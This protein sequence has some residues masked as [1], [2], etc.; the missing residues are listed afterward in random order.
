MIQIK[1]LI[2]KYIR[3]DIDGNEAGSETVLDGINLQI[4]EGEFVAILGR[5]GSGKSTFAKQLNAILRPS[6]GR[7]LV[8]GLDSNDDDNKYKIRRKAGMVF[9]NPDNQMV[10]S[11]V[12]EDVAFGPENLGLEPDEIKDKV[13]N[14]LKSVRMWN[15][16]DV[17]TGRLSGGQKQRVAIAGVLAMKPDYIILDEPTAMLDPEG[18]KEVIDTV[19]RLNKEK[20]M[21]VVLITHNIEEAINADRVVVLENGRVCADDTPDRIFMDKELIYKNGIT[22]PFEYRVWREISGGRKATV[23]NIEQLADKIAEL[24][25][26]RADITGDRME[27]AGCRTELDGHRVQAVAE[28][29]SDDKCTGT[30]NIS[31]DDESML[32]L[33]DVSYVYNPNTAYEKTAVRDISVAFKRGEFVGI[34]GHTGS[35]KSTLIQLFNGLLSPTNGCVMY[36]GKDI[37]SKETSKKYV[38]SKIGMVFQYP[39]HQMVKDT[40]YEDVTFGPGNLNLDKAECE[41]RAKTSLSMVGIPEEMWDKSPLQL[42]GGQ[43][44][45]VAIAGVLAMKPDFIILD[46]PAAGL[47]AEGKCEIFDWLRK[48]CEDDN[49]GIILVSHSMED[50]A[51]YAD[52]MIVLNDGRLIYD[53]TP[54]TVFSHSEELRKMGLDVPCAVKLMNELSLRG[55]QSCPDIVKEK[56]AIDR[57]RTWTGL[58]GDEND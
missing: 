15:Q 50:I 56:D 6:D 14:A 22:V 4:N 23:K 54:A 52:R 2:F 45:R 26:D 53:D 27:H 10:A 43:K 5:N 35:G 41:K 58:G 34:A 37:Y 42:S 31:V 7:V 20:N 11:V 21:T 18:R 48:T 39:E 36:E 13:D 30:P 1:Q 3:R 51:E 55:F 19:L 49:I 8:D 24:A 12:C 46:E 47:D 29:D 44:R 40:V 16:S 17:A 9:Q 28:H 33:K 38:R 25:G 57:I 32:V